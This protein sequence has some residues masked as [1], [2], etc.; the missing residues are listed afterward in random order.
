[1]LMVGRAVLRVVY[2]DTG[3]QTVQVEALRGEVIDRAERLQSYGFT[4]HPKPGADAVVLA[5]GGIRQHPIIMI[6]D[7]RNRMTDLDEGEVAMYGPNDG[8]YI[9]MNADGTITL[10]TLTR[11]VT[12]T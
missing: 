8:Q 7:R 11:E 12:I 4:S 2:D 3:L 9:K 6:D 10:K 5:V 1:M